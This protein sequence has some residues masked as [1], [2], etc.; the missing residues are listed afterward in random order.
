MKIGY[1]VQEQT[2]KA[3][4]LEQGGAITI[5]DSESESE[6]END[7]TPES[8]VS[9]HENQDQSDLANYQLARDRVR[10]QIKPPTR[11]DEDNEVS[12]ALIVVECLSLEEP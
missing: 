10:R 8:A 2:E 1:K 5:T 4:S 3:G 11:F 6:N 9:S 12:F 7:E